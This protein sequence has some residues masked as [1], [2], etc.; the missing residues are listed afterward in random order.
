MILRYIVDSKT[1]SLVCAQGS[2]YIL[3]YLYFFLL[4]FVIEEGVLPI[5]TTSEAGKSFWGKRY[6][7]VLYLVFGLFIVD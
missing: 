5:T 2:G 4:S 6:A 7:E 3:F 1:R